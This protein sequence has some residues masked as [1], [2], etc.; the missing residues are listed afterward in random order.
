MKSLAVENSRT[1][2]FTEPSRTL[3]RAPGS[4]RPLSSEKVERF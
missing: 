2:L 4:W 1:D 3:D